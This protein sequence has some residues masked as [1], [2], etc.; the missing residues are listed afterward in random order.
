VTLPD[1]SPITNEDN[2]A[3]SAIGYKKRDPVRM[4]AIGSFVRPT[5]EYGGAAAGGLVGSGIGPEGTIAG[6]SL[7]YAAGK[8]IADLI[9][10]KAQ[11]R[12]AK[13]AAGTLV[14]D[15]ATGAVMEMAGPI[16]G[17]VASKGAKGSAEIIKQTLGATTGAGPGM[18]DEAILGSRGFK[19][20]MRGDI[21]GREVVDNALSALQKVRDLRAERYIKIFG[22]ISKK[23]DVIDLEPI[24]NKLASLLDNYNVKI[25][26]EGFDYSRIAMGKKGRKDIEEIVDLVAS[27]GSKEGDTS[28]VGMDVLKRQLD[29]FYSDSSQARA[30][31]RSLR[32]SVKNTISKQVPEYSKMTEDYSKATKII[33][34]IES[35]LMM[36]KSGMSGR[37]TPDQTL[38]RLTSTMR[39]NFELRRDLVSVL[40]RESAVD[41][42]GQVAG[43]SAS[44][45]IPRGLI[46]KVAAGSLGYL[47]TIN[48]S[49][50][51]LLAASSPRAVGE[52]LTVYGRGLKQ[53]HRTNSLKPIAKKAIGYGAV[54]S[55]TTGQE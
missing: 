31:V 13:E 5:L 10:G 15:L 33:K 20:A 55:A 8:Q 29:D 24:G 30:F 23:N 14:K 34:D 19:S 52:F 1:I 22:N 26:D 42:S 43:Y 28:I 45:T 6:G 35:N 50:F 17:E 37:I 12:G 49:I 32:N 41:I 51:P 36:R 18:I 38:R 27:W 2:I 40:N 44:Q 39:E 21:T 9:E 48:P 46:G 16:I 53:L 54:K 11:K 4:T 3:R 25:T 47:G 7:G